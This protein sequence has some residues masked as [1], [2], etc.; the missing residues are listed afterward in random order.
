MSWTLVAEVPGWDE[1]WRIQWE[2]GAVRTD[3][4]GL[5]SELEAYVEEQVFVFATPVGPWAP[6]DLAVS[7]VAFSLVRQFLWNEW[8]VRNTTVKGRG[9]LWPVEEQAPADAV[10]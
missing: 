2:G 8:D 10:F 9:W 5:L 4:V 3:P 1:P 6:A 7:H